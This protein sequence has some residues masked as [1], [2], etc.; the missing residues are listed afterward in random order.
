[1]SFGAN[2]RTVGSSV[3]DACLSVGAFGRATE[4]V[5]HPDGRQP[6]M[7][8]TTDTSTTPPGA[9]TADLGA[10][11]KAAIAGGYVAHPPLATYTVTSPIVIYVNSTVQGPLGIDLGGA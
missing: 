11:L 5:F 8:T 10:W 7:A 3:I 4:A 6:S 1:M 9:D 2:L